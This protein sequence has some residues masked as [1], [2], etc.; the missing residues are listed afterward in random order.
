MFWLS[1]SYFMVLQ[2]YYDNSWK[3]TLLRLLVNELSSFTNV[4][5]KGY[6]YV[7]I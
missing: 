1:F 7:S 2:V 6:L 4:L 5:P 3:F